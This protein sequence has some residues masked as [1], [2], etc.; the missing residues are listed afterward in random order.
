[1]KRAKTYEEIKPL[2][3]LCK[4]GKLFE[5]QAWI[6]EG[7]PVNPPLPPEKGN[8]RKIPLEIAISCGFHSLV[9]VLLEGGAAIEEPRY[10][11]LEQA[12]SNRRLDLVKLLVEHGA[13]IHSVDM[14]W[15]FDTWDPKIMEYFIENGADAETGYPLAWAFISRI[16]T[17]LGIFKRYKD[18]FPSF[19][20]QVNIALRH[21]CKEGNLKWASLM[22]W[23]G[24]DPYARGPEVPDGE[25]DPEEDWNALELAA[26][27]GHFE[28]FGLK[29]ILLDPSRPDTQH[30]LRSVCY[31]GNA[32]LLKELL[33]TGFNPVD[34]EN[35]GSSLIQYLIQGMGWS[36]DINPFKDDRKKNI[37]TS[38]TREKI[39]MIHMLAKHGAKW[40]PNDRSE[41]ADARRSL[42]RLS[43]D[44]TMEFIWIMTKYNA[45]KRE[46]IAQ[47]INSPKMRILLSTHLPRL[48]ELIEEH[49]G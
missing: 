18:R 33:D 2:I 41:I 9:Q 12:L 32:K 46:D 15:V 26:F 1:M 49:A 19:K 25:P 40:V 4:E 45:C 17:S 21:H 42:L 34:Q 8:R 6:S 44:Y 23:A 27:H 47:L 5:I 13:D 10:S 48:K 39:K 38:R 37:D 3:K 20:E 29:Q 43:P 36:L 22:L 11:A 28:V 7:K 30:L 31:S 16:R 14:T 24:G 35:G